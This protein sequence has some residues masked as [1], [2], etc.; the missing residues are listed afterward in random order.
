MKSSAEFVP[1]RAVR[2]RLVGQLS[3]AGV[4]TMLLLGV[5]SCGS[6]PTPSESSVEPETVSAEEFSDTFVIAG[7]TAI[8]TKNTLSLSGTSGVYWMADRPARVD[9]SLTPLRLSEIWVGVGFADDPPNA[10]VVGS[11]EDGTAFASGVILQNPSYS[12]GSLSFAISYTT[13]YEEPLPTTISR[14]TV[15]IDSST[16]LADPTVVNSV[17]TNPS[18]TE[19]SVPGYPYKFTREQLIAL[20]NEIIAEKLDQRIQTPPL[21]WPA[22]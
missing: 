2:T 7:D 5:T 4:A 13:T 20:L 1:Q 6:V 19:Y 9:G 3:R 18:P 11:R 14:A 16:P 17:T 21:T 15:I 8:L 10:M 22:S 12:A